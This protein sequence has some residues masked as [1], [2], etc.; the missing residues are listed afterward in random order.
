MSISLTPDDDED[1]DKVGANLKP[2]LSFTAPLCPLPP[3]PPPLQAKWACFHPFACAKITPRQSGQ[4]PLA[5]PPLTNL[6]DSPLA[7]AS[8]SDGKQ[9]KEF[10][11]CQFAMELLAA[12]RLTQ[13]ANLFMLARA[14]K[15]TP[16]RL[17]GL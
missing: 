3:P 14:D 4:L 10:C 2:L 7:Q 13:V 11:L 5:S 9:A 6:R 8:A 16:T 17:G 15:F 1:D 12:R